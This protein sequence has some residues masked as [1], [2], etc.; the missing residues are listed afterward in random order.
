MAVKLSYI[1]GFP[2][3]SGNTGDLQDIDIE[4]G[5]DGYHYIIL[6]ENLE[7]E[8]SPSTVIEFLHQKTRI[9]TQAYIFPSLPSEL[10]TQGAIM[11]DSKKNLED[12]SDFLSN[13]DHIIVS[14]KGRY[15]MLLNYNAQF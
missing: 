5:R 2:F 9:T 11:L 10:S 6:L 12:L 14:S 8:L 13:P 4:I 3:L 7:K 1:S 15:V